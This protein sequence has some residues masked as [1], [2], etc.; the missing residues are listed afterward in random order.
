MTL[1]SVIKLFR[2]SLSGL[3]L[4]CP[5]A[6]VSPVLLRCFVVGIDV[7]G[8]DLPLLCQQIGCSTSL[9]LR[10]EKDELASKEPKEII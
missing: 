7:D 9:L 4:G 6:K 3:A 5:F 10:E 2:E 8:G 1:S